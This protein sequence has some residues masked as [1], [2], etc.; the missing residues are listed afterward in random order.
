VLNQLRNAFDRIDVIGN[1]FGA[2][3]ALW[4]LVQP[5]APVEKIGTLFLLAGAQGVDTDP[6]QGIMRIWNPAFLSAPVIWE[7]IELDSPI[8]I[9]QT[10]REAYADIAARA[11]N[12]PESITIKYM[13]VTADELLKVSDSE[14]FR[15]KIM[16]GRGEIILNQT[17]R[18]YPAHGLLAHD[19]P[20]LT[21]EKLMEYLQ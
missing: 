2:V 5:G 15:D 9:N 10:L 8:S 16:K 3:S 21:S 6:M 1:S 18:A 14:H 4:S 19:T 13:V 20:D 7:K 12:L 17:D 11:A